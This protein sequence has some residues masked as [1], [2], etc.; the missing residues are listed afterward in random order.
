MC[1]CQ[2][3]KEKQSAEDVRHRFLFQ[4]HGFTIDEL[5]ALLS[6]TAVTILG[7]REIPEAAQDQDK[8]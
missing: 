6:S 7:N 3:Y 2:F 5:P 1:L 8:T 4:E